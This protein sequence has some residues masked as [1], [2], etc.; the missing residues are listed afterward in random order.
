MRTE[1]R[2]CSTHPRAHWPSSEATASM[3]GFPNLEGRPTWL[4]STSG[5]LAR[6]CVT[7][8]AAKAEATHQPSRPAGGRSNS[9][10]GGQCGGQ[11]RP[12]AARRP[13]PPSVAGGLRG[14]RESPLRSQPRP[15][16]PVPNTWRVTSMVLVGG[17][18]AGGNKS[19]CLPQLHPVGQ[20]PGLVGDCSQLHSGGAC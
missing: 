15:A 3:L 8:G 16:P 10:R 2:V 12:G 14:E 5:H 9:T 19:L 20:R 13:A 7:D 4:R 17:V 6:T 18:G 11:Q 1:P